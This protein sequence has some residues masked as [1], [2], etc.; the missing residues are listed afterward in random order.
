ME[1][2]IFDEP[3]LNGSRARRKDLEEPAIRVL[4]RGGELCESERLA[5]AAVEL[6]ENDVHL[7]EEPLVE[8]LVVRV[9][10]EAA[11]ALLPLVPGVLDGDGAHGSIIGSSSRQHFSGHSGSISAAMRSPSS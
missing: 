8:R 2:S 3:D 4:I 9:L 5:D 1:R 10:A 7:R 11:V 6:V